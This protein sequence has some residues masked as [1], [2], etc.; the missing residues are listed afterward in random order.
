[1]SR[2]LVIADGHGVHGARWVEALC[3]LGHVVHWVATRTPTASTVAAGTSV[4]MDVGSSPVRGALRLMQNAAEVRRVCR[5]FKPDL[6]QAQFLTPCGWYGWMARCRP[7]TVQLWGSDILKHA[8]QPFHYRW[9]STRALAGAAAVTADSQNLIDV[10]MAVSP[11]LRPGPV[12]SWGVDTAVFKPV[13]A[14][15]RAELKR[16]LAIDTA[17]VI[18]CT[19]NFGPDMNVAVLVEAFAGIAGTAARDC[20][21]VLKKGYPL[22]MDATPVGKAIDGAGIADRVRVIDEEYDYKR[23]AGLYAAADV[24]VSIPTPGRDGLSQSLLDALASGCVPV[25]SRNRDTME[26]I[27]RDQA[28]G[29]VVDDP[30]DVRSVADG[31]A[32]ALQI[33]SHDPHV[34]MRNRD[35]IERNYERRICMSHIEEWIGNVLSC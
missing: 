24:F 3:E 2:I 8:A 26:V 35:Y 6:I 34:T 19:R 11:T 10:A 18:L 30:R 17:H 28:A 7:Y 20:T 12:L 27:G 1:M 25:V 9:L 22:E 5:R 32:A 15:R 23:M 29:V 14:T 33:R 13:D 4:L 16:S 21:L 31:C